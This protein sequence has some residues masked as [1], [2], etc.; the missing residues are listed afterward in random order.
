MRH[1]SDGKLHIVKW[2]DTRSVLI[3]SN[4]VESS[5]MVQAKRLRKG[6]ASK[7]EVQVPKM[8]QIYNARMGGVDKADQ[9]KKSCEIDHR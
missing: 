8:V 2:M 6:Q 9:P 1:I 7:E 3:L 5:E 4:F